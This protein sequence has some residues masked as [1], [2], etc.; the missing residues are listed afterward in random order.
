MGLFVSRIIFFIWI[1]FARFRHTGKVCS[2]DYK[3]YE[4]LK[5]GSNYDATM[6][7]TYCLFAGWVLKIFCGIFMITL[8]IRGLIQLWFGTKGDDDDD[9]DDNFVRAPNAKANRQRD[10]ENLLPAN[11]DNP[12]QSPGPFDRPSIK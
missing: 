11:F 10:T 1:L 12:S 3:D 6:D 7:Y 4:Q 9:D 2:G 5:S 8:I